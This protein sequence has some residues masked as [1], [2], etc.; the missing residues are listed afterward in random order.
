MI[1]R[2]SVDGDEITHFQITGIT[3]VSLYKNDGNSISNYEFISFAEC[4]AGL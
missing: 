4:N 3:N 1:S 2:T